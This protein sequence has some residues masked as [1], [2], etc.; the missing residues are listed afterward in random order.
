M[1]FRSAFTLS[2]SVV[3]PAG[4]SWCF[5]SVDGELGSSPVTAAFEQFETVLMPVRRAYSVRDLPLLK[6]TAVDSGLLSRHGCHNLI[7]GH[8]RG[9]LNRGGR[10]HRLEFTV[11]LLLP[12]INRLEEEGFTAHS[13]IQSRHLPI[14]RADFLLSYQK[15][16]TFI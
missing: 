10:R 9:L 6:Q 14:S 4:H 3:S 12:Y 2:V 1:A 8:F 11:D 15:G 16:S 7:F 5:R 13:Y